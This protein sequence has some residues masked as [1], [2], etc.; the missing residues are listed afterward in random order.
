M[1]NVKRTASV[2]S[3]QSERSNVSEIVETTSESD[4]MALRPEP[5]PELPIPTVVVE[6]KA[7]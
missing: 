1:Q 5:E 7:D 3:D 6:I 2:R 4:V